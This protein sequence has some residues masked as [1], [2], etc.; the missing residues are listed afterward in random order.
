MKLMTG[1]QIFHTDQDV[2]AAMDIMVN[3]LMR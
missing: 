3:Y 1:I 2:P